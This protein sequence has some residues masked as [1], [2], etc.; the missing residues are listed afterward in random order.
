[1]AGEGCTELPG[2]RLDFQWMLGN[3][4]DLFGCIVS[5]C[6]L[7]GGG[8]VYLPPVADSRGSLCPT[9]PPARKE[10][11]ARSHFLFRMG[12]GRIRA[13]EED[14]KMMSLNGDGV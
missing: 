6:V 5:Y 8:C 14:G 7:I 13:E 9:V 12:H 3:C 1:M 11:T 2:G 4:E 10:E